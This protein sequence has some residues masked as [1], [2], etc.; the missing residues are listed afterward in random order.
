[1]KKKA[2]KKEKKRSFTVYV[3]SKTPYSFPSVLV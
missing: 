3:N 2:T 1:M